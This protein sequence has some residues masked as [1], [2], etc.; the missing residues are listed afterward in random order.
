MIPFFYMIVTDDDLDVKSVSDFLPNYFSSFNTL[1]SVSSIPFSL[2]FPSESPPPS[3]ASVSVVAL[4]EAG[5]VRVTWSERILGTGQMIT[6]YSVQYRRRGTTSYITRSVSGS[7]TTSYNITNLKLGTVYEVRVASVGPLGLSAYCCGS[8]K[9][10]TT[11]NCEC[12]VHDVHAVQIVCRSLPSPLLYSKPI[13][14]GFSCTCEC[15][16]GRHGAWLIL[17]FGGFLILSVCDSSA[18]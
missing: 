3:S 7:S 18:S 8:G 4:N 2:C 5:K 1:S 6:G 11:Y 17:C 14:V 9:Q 15:K 12:N 13:S 10:V 16:P